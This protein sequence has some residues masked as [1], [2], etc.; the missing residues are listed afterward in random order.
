MIAQEESDK[1]SFEEKLKL[2]KQ[3][4][5]DETRGR[6]RRRSNSENFKNVEKVNKYFKILSCNT[7][8]C[9]SYGNI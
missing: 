4:E 9:D 6:A 5:A 1:T 3:R 2:E 7:L 8:T